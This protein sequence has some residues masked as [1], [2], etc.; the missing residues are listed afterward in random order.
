MRKRIGLL[1][2]A[3]FLG[4]FAAAEAASPFDGTYQVASATKVTQ[5]YVSRGGDM[6]QCPDRR[7]GP[8]TVANGSANYTTE[9][10]DTISGR[11]P[12]NGQ[13]EMRVVSTKGSGALK[14]MAAIE[15][16]GKA[17]VRQMGNSCTY[18]FVWQK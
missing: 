17:Y 13:F 10:G 1:S 9:T 15:A 8:F 14:V 12:P 5:T 18:D 11:V 4:L 16:N 3:A 6:G 2:I 7:P